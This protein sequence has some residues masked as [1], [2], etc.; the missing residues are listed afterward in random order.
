MRCVSCQTPIPE[1]SS[2]CPF[3][4]AAVVDPAAATLD[5]RA[6]DAAAP[7]RASRPSRPISS[8]SSVDG[9]RFVPGA[10]LLERYRI[11][12]L[13]GQRRHGRS[14]SRGRPQARTSGG[15]EVPS[16]QH[17]GRCCRTGPVPSR[18]THRETSVA[19]ERLPGLRHRRSGRP[20][21]LVDGVHR[22]RGSGLPASAHRAAACRTKRWRSR[23]NCAPGWRQ[24]TRRACCTAI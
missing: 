8:A 2:S 15:V 7:V 11:V 4:G 24:R 19:P 6:G 18:S 1:A 5:S 21:L 17:R 10:M 9:S 14:L 3:C 23:G 22:R 20:G 12:G 13:L 16:G